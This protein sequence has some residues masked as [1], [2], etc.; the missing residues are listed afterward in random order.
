MITAAPVRVFL[1]DDHDIARKGIAAAV[2]SDGGVTVIGEA[3]RI[4]DAERLILELRPDVA[5]LDA[6]LPDGSGVELCARLRRSCPSVRCLILTA[7]D[8]RATVVAAMRSGAAG[9]LLKEV[10][11]ESLAGAVRMVAAG[12]SLLDPVMSRQL[13]DWISAGGVTE[14][15]PGRSGVAEELAGLTD[16]QLRILALIAQGL[17]NREIAAELFL[18]EKTVKNHITRILA[19]LGVQRRTQAALLASR[20]LQH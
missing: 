6:A 7:Y 10:A 8:D 15:S 20:L 18:S 11:S 12:H 5:V 9:Y 3:G 16:Q 17:S 2:E 14:E 19:R 13:G 1:L 4:A